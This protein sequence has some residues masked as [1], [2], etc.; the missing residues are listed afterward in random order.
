M[1]SHTDAHPQTI[2]LRGP[3]KTRRIRYL[4]EHN[5]L[6]WRCKLYGIAMEGELPRDSL[7]ASARAVAERVLPQP[8]VTGPGGDDDRYGIG[9]IIAHDGRDRAYVIVAWFAGENEIYERLLSAPL[10]GTSQPEPH[11]SPAV[12]CVW[13]LEVVD[14]ERRA[15]LEHVLKGPD[16]EAYFAAHLNTEV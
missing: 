10:D 5:A 1:S 16:I 15:W 14:F 6:G 8:P 12:G 3:H 13:E 4:G 2:T 11:P 9:L 7:V